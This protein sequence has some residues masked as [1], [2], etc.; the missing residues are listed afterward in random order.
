LVTTW[1]ALP[2]AALADRDDGRAMIEATCCQ[3]QQGLG[4]VKRRQH[5]WEAPQMVLLWARLAHHLL[6]WSQRWLS[7]VPAMRWR[8]RGD[9]VVR[10]LQEVWTVP[11]IMPRRKGWRV[12]VHFDPL[13]PRA[14]VLQEGFAAL[15]RGRVR[16]RCLR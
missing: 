1:C 15:F 8:L 6:R 10:R 9:G 11:G 13:H 5:R 16:V 4:L 14:K 12:S 2:P 3:D 7:R